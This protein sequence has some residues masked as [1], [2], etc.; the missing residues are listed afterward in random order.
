[1]HFMVI[2]VDTQE[3]VLPATL[4]P[5]L[6]LFVRG[7]A[8]VLSTDGPPR[9]TPRFCVSG[10][11]PGA[12]YVKP[13]PGTLILAVLFRPGYLSWELNLAASQLVGRELDLREVANTGPIDTMFSALDQTQSIAEYVQ[14]FQRYLLDTLKLERTS[15]LAESFLTNHQKLFFP[16][17][18]LALYFGIGRR[19]VERRILEVFGLPLRE[20]RR[21][22]RWGFCLERLV[23]TRVQRGDLTRIACDSGYFDQAHMT[24]E[25]IEFSGLAPLPLLKKIASG[26]PAYW[27]YRIN[28]TNYRDLFIPVR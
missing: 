1:M 3:Y 16:L 27:A 19:Q 18:D 4:S 8:A 15:S 10:P 11:C 28:G 25:F 22:A 23:N 2:D 7:A 17:V 21:I 20:V 26:D 13:S 12:R 9:P 24:R 14:I 6:I 5:A